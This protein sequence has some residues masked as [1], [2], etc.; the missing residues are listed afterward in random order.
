MS[1]SLAEARLALQLHIGWPE[2]A[3]P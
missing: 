1:S 3:D 2:Q